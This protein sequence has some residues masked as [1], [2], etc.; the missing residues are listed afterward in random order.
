MVIAAASPP[1]KL[2]SSARRV[3]AMLTRIEP[4]NTGPKTANAPSSTAFVAR[5]VATPGLLWVSEVVVSILR[6]RMPPAAL[7]SLTASS[8]PFL[9]FVP[10]V[11]PAPESS[12]MLWILIGCA[13]AAALP[14]TA[15]NAASKLRR[16]GH[17]RCRR[18]LWFGLR[19]G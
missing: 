3:S 11:A 7:I 18:L 2:G 13:N 9:K 15:A 5:P 1:V 17:M 14:N 12:T 16:E 4:E 10:E 6:P 8:T 19:R